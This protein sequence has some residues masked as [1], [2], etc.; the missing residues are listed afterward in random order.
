[1]SVGVENIM[2]KRWFKAFARG[3]EP[4]LEIKQ[5][6]SKQKRKLSRKTRF[7]SI[8]VNSESYH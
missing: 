1:M 5:V 4:N 7:I 2:M 3:H 8:I 6:V